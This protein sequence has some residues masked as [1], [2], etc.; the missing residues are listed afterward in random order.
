MTW[1]RFLHKMTFKQATF[2]YKSQLNIKYIKI[3]N[4]INYVTSKIR[5]IIKYATTRHKA[6]FNTTRH[7]TIFLTRDIFNTRTT[8][9]HKTI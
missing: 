9:K 8:I 4:I 7:Q 5:N 6:T 2:K 3:G 1:K